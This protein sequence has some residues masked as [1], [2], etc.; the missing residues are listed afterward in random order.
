MMESRKRPGSPA[1][2]P[3]AS[4]KRALMSATGA[5]V[6]VNGVDDTEQAEPSEDS[7]LELFRKE[8][9]YRRMRHYAREHERGRRRI[10]QLEAARET[11][12]ASM[13]AIETCWNQL[14]SEIRALV[15][16]DD[17]K[18]SA[19]VKLPK[20]TSDVPAYESALKAKSSETKSLVNAFVDRAGSHPVDTTTLQA[21]RREAESEALRLQSE[22]ELLRAQIEDANE[23]M[24]KMRNDLESADN[25]VE[26]LKRESSRAPPTQPGSVRA[27]DEEQPDVKPKMEPS[28]SPA[29]APNGHIVEFDIAKIESAQVET[30]MAMVRERDKEIDRLKNEVYSLENGTERLKEDL[31]KSRE[32]CSKLDVRLQDALLLDAIDE[33]VKELSE[34]R[35]KEA[36]TLRA[37]AER[38]LEMVYQARSQFEDGVRNSVAA[39]ADEYKT[40]LDRNAEDTTR[41]RH[42]RDVAQSELAERKAALADKFAS[43][44]E[45]RALAE[46][47]QERIDSLQSEVQRLQARIAAHA[48]DEDL[49]AFFTNEANVQTPYVEDLRKRLQD[50]EDKLKAQQE[51]L[52]V[53]AEVG[54]PNYDYLQAELQARQLAEELKRRLAK[55]EA[56]YGQQAL[57]TAAP[58]VQALAQTLEEKEK[59][60]AASELLRKQEAEALNAL[61]A[62]VDRLSAS[63]ETMERQFRSK[64]Y[65]LAG[66]EEKL[67][68]LTVEKCKADNKYFATMRVKDLAEMEVKSLKTTADRQAAHIALLEDN[69][70]AWQNLP[71]K[72]EE[73]A[74]QFAKAKEA[75]EKRIKT[76]EERNTR[77]ETT[78]HENNTAKAKAEARTKVLEGENQSLRSQSERLKVQL[79]GSK[80]QVKQL[81]EKLEQMKRSVASAAGAEDIQKQL[82]RS[83]SAL[84]C[85]TCKQ[86]F[87]EQVLVKCGHTFCKGCID[88]RLSTRQRK[89]PACNLPFAQS[90]VLPMFLQ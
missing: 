70:A 8:A 11:Y 18:S 33:K 53:H 65:E 21:A 54:T 19:R 24:D 25:R 90:D 88:S 23:Q 63:W 82:D 81:A 80:S 34:Q 79:D 75:Y 16:L 30:C 28:P 5:P 66:M 4:K 77:F 49:F 60:L 68:R 13:L 9:I 42:Q 71:K 22:C 36:N 26:R 56:T 2:D 83:M 3:T 69:I 6:H 10:E 51:V 14:I 86:N 35:V 64:V 41:L 48:G 52:D 72:H 67:Q 58:D 1:E 31:V 89:C 45:Y 46:A 59:A 29:A 7:N 32:A 15:T 62:D 37:N 20:V 27:P 47:R 74:T 43:I 78:Q 76:L 85:S 73:L 61:Y 84:K 57:E 17:N 50:A 87:R 40:Q 38:E 12:Q 55:F 39:Q 44:R